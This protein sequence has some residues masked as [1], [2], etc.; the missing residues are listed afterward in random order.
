MTAVG[1]TPCVPCSERGYKRC[2]LSMHS[3]GGE[4]RGTFPF[5]PGKTRRDKQSGAWANRF[6]NRQADPYRRAG[7]RA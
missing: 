2:W 7:G 5:R 3:P 6:A 4:A 1:Y